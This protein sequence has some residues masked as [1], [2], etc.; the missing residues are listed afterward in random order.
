MTNHHFIDDS[1]SQDSGY[2]ERLK[3]NETHKSF[4]FVEPSG[5]APRVRS[6]HAHSPYHSPYLSPGAISSP[7]LKLSS[8]SCGS[9]TIENDEEFMSEVFVGNECEDADTSLCSVKSMRS[10]LTDD[11][12][13]SPCHE[14]QVHETPR[15]IEKKRNNFRR[16]LSLTIAAEVL[17][18]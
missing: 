5:T 13:I 10:L 9:N 4:R 12:K 14:K 17:K 7:K 11:I 6:K 3:C 16:C 18:Y 1:N 2:A 15:I 8:D